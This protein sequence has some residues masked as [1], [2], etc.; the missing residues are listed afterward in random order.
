MKSLLTG[1]RLTLALCSSAL[2][3]SCLPEDKDPARET[4]A[5]EVVSSQYASTLGNIA[6]RAQD[7]ILKDSSWFTNVSG[8]TLDLASYG[9]AQPHGPSAAIRTAVCPTGSTGRLRQ[10]T[11]LDA[12]DGAGNFNVSR[13]GNSSGA[14]LTALRKS[15]GGDQIGTYRGNNAIEM[16][17][18][19]ILSI[20]AT[21]HSL[22]LPLDAPVVVFSIDRPAS[23][24]VAVSKKEYRAV[25]CPPDASGRPQRGALVQTRM[26]TFGPNGFS[27]SPSSDAGWQT[28]DMGQCIEDVSVSIAGRDNLAG[29]GTGDLSAFAN[30]ALRN[31]LA[32][33]IEMDCSKTVVAGTKRDGEERVTTGFTV[34]T[35]GTS[36]A[37]SEVAHNASEVGTNEESR[38]LVCS[39]SFDNPSAQ[40]G[41]IPL[42]GGRVT[43]EPRPGFSN[44]A[45]LV[46]NR[47][48]YD[49]NTREDN[50][51][52]RGKWVAN[53]F[54]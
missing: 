53:C 20:P 42:S 29:G 30:S 25:A 17:D 36:A 34:D 51:S 5:T 43:W 14:I 15:M 10:I 48:A 18:G 16:G 50:Q 23:P 38:E 26:I 32:A 8:A 54:C 6:V 9:V 40:L 47:T 39:G 1:C 22:S 2:L 46:Q 7:I 49:L 37:G 19:N 41:D 24:A 45:T 33:Q 27:P 11:W 21:C 28:D 3:L 52:S 4:V 44:K 12:N 35:C 13:L 31:L